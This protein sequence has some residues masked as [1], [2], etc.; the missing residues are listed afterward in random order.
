[1]FTKLLHMYISGSS[2]PG[3]KGARADGIIKLPF[4]EEQTSSDVLV[5]DPNC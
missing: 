4:T 1:M 5:L 2:Q 3:C